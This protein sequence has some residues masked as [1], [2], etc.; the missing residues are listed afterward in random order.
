[1]RGPP[2]KADREGRIKENQ[3]GGMKKARQ[4]ENQKGELWARRFRDRHYPNCMPGQSEAPPGLKKF[5]SYFFFA[6]FVFFAF[7]AFFAFLAIASSF[8]LM[9]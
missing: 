7:F 2:E 5:R 4:D 9:D 3:I 1:V 8:E 6:F